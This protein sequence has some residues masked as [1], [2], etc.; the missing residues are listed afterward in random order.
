[1][2]GKRLFTLAPLI[3]ALAACAVGP[4]FRTP[5]AP[6]A[7]GYTRGAL[8]DAAAT[9]AVGTA[10]AAQWWKAYGSPEL[11]ALVDKALAR[12]PNIDV[13]TAN[14][15]VAQ[16]NVAAQRGFFYPT[17]QAGYART[18]QNSGNTLS[19][20]LNSGDS[21]FN[22]HAAQLSVGFVPDV[23]GVN[24]RQ[25]ESLEAQAE[26]QRYQLAALRI[27]LAA[28]VVAAALQEAVVVEQIRLTVESIET[29]R[30]LLT[31]L[32]RMRA[33][34]YSS[35][36]DVATVEAALAQA[37]QVLPPLNRQLEQTRDL[38]AVLCGD[39][40]EQRYAPVRLDTVRVPAALPLA[41]PS[42]LVRQRPDVRAA[43][44][45]VHA[46]NA[47]VGVAIGNLLPQ[48]QLTAL[49]GG[50]ATTFAQMFASGNAIW[51][52]GG[53]VGQTLFAGGTLTARKRA[54]E[55]ALEGALA[56][57]R[58]TVITAFQN[59]ADTLYA[60]DT[61][62]QALKAA[63]DAEAAN[64]KLLG[65]TQI[66]FDAGYSAEPVLLNARLL[67]LQASLTRLQSLGTYLVDTTALFQAMGGDWATATASDARSQASTAG[68]AP[69][70]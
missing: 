5:A 57:Y 42:Q 39:A 14:L 51:A 2:T 45:Q 62:A 69:R 48:F 30:G 16:E 20:P 63:S 56:Q 33:A 55:A 41:L 17:V 68:A 53:G 28:N 27:T 12:N 19:S 43:E 65:L 37:Q 59:V 32:R 25:V 29:N 58:A 70:Q 11:D 44:A 13:A 47:Q 15:K 8:A 21:I 50:A 23:F 67:V 3:A 6:Q 38:L 24:R 31:H 36:I 9:L 64:R 10:I 35:A 49:L 54:A 18:R 4:D 1:M 66:A 61:D 40:P 7:S 60:L 34:G 26:G 52:I 22:L 46:A